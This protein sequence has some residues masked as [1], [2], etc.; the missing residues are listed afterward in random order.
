MRHSLL[1]RSATCLILCATPIGAA[2]E[3]A[4]PGDDAPLA[5]PRLATPAPT[6][7]E[8]GFD[9]LVKPAQPTPEEAVL[10]LLTLSETEQAAVRRVLSARARIIDEFIAG[11][12]PML[13]QFGVA[14]GTG[15]KKEQLA[16]AYAAML[17][18]KPLT[19]GG[20]LQDQVR[21]AL[22]PE[23]AE[24]FDRML[25]DYWNAFVKDR[26]A[27]RKPDGTFPGRFEIIAAAKLESLGKEGERAFQ[28]MMNGGDL[29]YQ[30]LFKGIELR[31]EQAATLR[32]FIT[33][34]ARRTKGEATNEQN[35]QLFF[36]ILPVLDEAQKRQFGAN[37]RELSGQ[38]P[39]TAAKAPPAEE[40]AMDK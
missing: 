16:L 8:R 35:A 33:D 32:E 39:A 20:P 28:Q 17:K 40:K 11:N 36:R 1:V 30:Y 3:A 25:K 12:I 24:K 7:I 10:G 34:F 38:K 29:V 5:G 9:G 2:R 26:R 18:L 23:N 37:I 27:I 4:P 31:P 15:D 6:I 13:T 19:D 22:G 14:E 21:G